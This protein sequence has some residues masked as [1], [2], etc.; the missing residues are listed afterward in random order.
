LPVEGD[1]P[2]AADVT[3]AHVDLRGAQGVLLGPGGAVHNTFLQQGHRAR[4]PQVVGRIPPEAGSRQPRAADSALDAYLSPSA[5][6]GLV[7]VVVGTSGTGKTQVAAAAARRA[8]DAGHVELVVWVH[9]VSQ[10]AVVARYSQAVTAATGRVYETPVEGAEAFMSWLDTDHGKRW[11]VVL[12]DLRTPS[13]MVGWWPPA[14]RWGRTL[15]TTWRRDHAL[16]DSRQTLELGVFSQAESYSYLRDKLRDRRSSLVGAV[17]LAGDLGHLPLALAQAVSFIADEGL[18]CTAY[19]RLFADQSRKLETL[20]GDELPDEHRATVAATWMLSI[21]LA[22]RQHPQ[23]LAGAVL[24]LASLLDS[25]SAPT[26]VLLNRHALRFLSHNTE[27]RRRITGPDVE[28]AL[29]VLQ[30]LSLASLDTITVAVHGLIQRATRD[31]TPERHHMPIAHAVADALLDI[32]PEPERSPELAQSLRTN[33]AALRA[34]ADRHLVHLGRGAHGVYFRAIES[35]GN[36]GLPWDARTQSIELARRCE[37]QLGPRHPDCIAARERAA[38]WLGQAG[39]P[40]GAVRELEPL[41]LQ[42]DEALGPN[43]RLTLGVRNTLAHHRGEAGDVSS[44]IAEYTALVRD[45]ERAL[46]PTDPLTLGV[47]G[48]LVSWVDTA[49]S[50]MTAAADLAATVADKTSTLGAD[51]AST[52]SSRHNYAAQCRA[53]GYPALAALALVEIIA[54]LERTHGADHP[55]TLSSRDELAGCFLDAW[56]HDI[57]ATEFSNVLA[58]KQTALG[59]DHALTLLTRGNLALAHGLLGDV[60]RAAADLAELLKDEMRALGESNPQIE[61][62]RETLA[63]FR[64]WLAGSHRPDPPRWVSATTTAVPRRSASPPDARSPEALAAL[65]VCQLRKHGPDDEV[66]S[67]TRDM[68]VAYQEW[69][70]RPGGEP[71]VE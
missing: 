28:A 56:L 52:L 43:D 22:E 5:L 44:A 3:T 10:D 29:R 68:L 57:A 64:Q 8:R 25:D 37:E 55:W 45:T 58:A 23:G 24:A 35:I 17:E 14:A 46:G 7:P 40:A 20:A 26:A 15:V 11:L 50:P 71:R 49:G 4:W 36:A 31:A 9:A 33:A 30:R 70:L 12:D 65:F 53:S 18:T 39:D 59:P 54:E 6:G 27:L 60:E 13:D 51:H 21:E 63:V 66:N 38:N 47:R 42:A 32:W 62:T 41:A 67:I 61:A 19:R 34:Y 16:H 48:N 2:P 1:D 69:S